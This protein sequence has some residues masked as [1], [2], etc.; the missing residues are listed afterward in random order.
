MKRLTIGG[1]LRAKIKR[2]SE[3]R[4]TI[5]EYKNIP[6]VRERLKNILKGR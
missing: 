3:A 4:E 6:G 1:V 5:R 2:E